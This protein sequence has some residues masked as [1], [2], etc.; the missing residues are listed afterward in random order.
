[1]TT[2]SATLPGDPGAV[3]V[4]PVTGAAEAAA[5]LALPAALRVEGWSVPLRAEEARLFDPGWNG[6]W[7]DHDIGRFLAWRDGRPVGRI[8]AC[9]PRH[10][11]AP[12][13]FGFLR[14]A[15]DGVALGA[16]LDAARAFVAARGGREMLGPLSFT[17]NHE[18]G[19]QLGDFDRPPMLRM[20]R[21]PPWLPGMLEAAGLEPAKDVLA[22]TLDVA[23]ERHRAR[24][25]ALR[26]RQPGLAARLSVRRLDRRDWAA[27]VRRVAALYDAAWAENWGAV[28]LRPA[29]VETLGR[30]LRPLLW[31]GEVFFALLDGAPA[32]L[33]S[34]VP[35]IDAALPA[36]GRLLPFGW[37]RL[38]AALAGKGDSARVPMLG[39]LPGVRGTPAG[40][41]ALGLLLD[42][43]IGHAA[44]RGWRRLE[45][46]W[47]LEDNAAMLNAMARLPAPVDGR[48]RIWRAGVI[49]ATGPGR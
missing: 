41:L 48:W 15:R 32:G 11:N 4:R 39:L 9:V 44:S 7:A 20:P 2:R 14:C 29:E 45:I 17:I 38:T 3:T 16:L 13:T 5:F 18:V 42:Q 19:A 23:A 36:D 24:F 21:T 26:A 40:A 22:C 37:A 28:P 33:V 46:S 30:L 6:F 10:P 12:A 47:I 8:A 49:P 35:N 31:R 34:V 25:A 27:E 43:A 1:M